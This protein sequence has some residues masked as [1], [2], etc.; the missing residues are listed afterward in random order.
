[1]V[2]GGAVATVL[3]ILAI[4]VLML[5]PPIG[6]Y[7]A[8]ALLGAGIGLIVGGVVAATAGLFMK[9]KRKEDAR[10]SA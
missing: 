2:T 8:A 4:G 1:M 6:G 3:G 5:N 10:K 7:I 9:P